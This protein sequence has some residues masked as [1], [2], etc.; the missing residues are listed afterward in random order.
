MILPRFMYRKAASIEEALALYTQ[1][2]PEA[3]YLSGGTDLMPRVKLRLAKPAMLID[4]KGITD[5][6]TVEEEN[7]RIRIGAL[8]AISDLE[9]HP[10]VQEY[11]PALRASLKATS[12]ETLRMRGTIGGNLLQNSRCLFYNQSEFWRKSKGFCLKMGG[13][14]CNAVPGATVCLANYCSDNA[15]AL[16]TLSAEI[17]LAG[18][19][20]QR[21]IPLTDL[22]SGKSGKPFLLN[23]G[24]IL[25]HVLVPKRKTTGDYEKLRIR[26]A[27]DYPLLGVAL[28]TFGGKS[29]FAVGAI[30]PKPNVFET[31]SLDEQGLQEVVKEARQA[32]RPAPNT[33]VDTAY[34]RDMIAILVHRVAGRA[35]EEAN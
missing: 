17:R 9:E 29:R 6:A 33:V 4:L 26:G 5:L 21:E 24:E 11:F 34:R 23:A 31:D 12:C 3:L 8:S 25:T 30:G 1:S 35:A 13:D 14:K 16:L 15:P 27:I 19:D 10:V 32:A 7:G 2:G 20:G 22:Y 18:P 28:T